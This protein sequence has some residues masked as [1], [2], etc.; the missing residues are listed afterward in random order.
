MFLDIS[1]NHFSPSFVAY[2]NSVI[3]ICMSLNPSTAFSA[4]PLTFVKCRMDIAN[5]T[6]VLVTRLLDLFRASMFSFGTSWTSFSSACAISLRT[7]VARVFSAT[8]GRFV[9]F[10]FYS[11]DFRRS[12]GFFHICNLGTK[13]V[14]LFHQ[15]QYTLI[16]KLQ[17][18]TAVLRL[19]RSASSAVFEAFDGTLTP[20][21]YPR[22]TFSF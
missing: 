5:W 13:L 19:P 15:L 17:R 12:H 18:F 4:S 20:I 6:A 1:V 16:L 10:F 7:R 14:R 3:C 11:S 22:T 2:P 9:P 21:Q 8:V